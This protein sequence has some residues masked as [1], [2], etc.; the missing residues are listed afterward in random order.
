MT[1]SLAPDA[2]RPAWVPTP[3]ERV[4]VPA[5]A[6]R[7]GEVRTW[8]RATVR[9]PFPPYVRVEITKRGKA[10]LATY[11][12]CQILPDQGGAR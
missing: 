5:A 3:G 2:S 10:T 7:P 8:W 4:Q 1:T 6:G 11:L 9:Y 12:I